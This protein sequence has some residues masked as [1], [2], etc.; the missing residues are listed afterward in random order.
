MYEYDPIP[1]LE[2][3][4]YTEREASFLYLVGRNSG[5]FLRRQFLQFAQ[6]HAGALAQNFVNK[7]LTDRYAK[8]LD[9]G[10]RRHI[11]HLHSGSIYAILRMQD[12]TLRRQ[13]S[14]HEMV[15]RLLILDY[16]L[17]QLGLRW[18]STE[19]EKAEYLE[20]ELKINPECFPRG[21]PRA[22]SED[23]PGIR[24]FP[25]H[26]PF[27]VLRETK[28][29]KPRIR[30]TYFD[31]GTATVKAFERY[32]AI[33]RELFL[34]LSD[35]DLAYVS[36]SSRNFFEAER[37]FERTLSKPKKAARL[38]PKGP[39]H[40]ARYFAAQESW[41]RTDPSFSVADLCSL[42][43]GKPIY[44]QPEHEILRAAWRKG[45]ATFEQALT[46][47][48]QRTAANAR[49]T[50]Q[51]MQRSYPIFGYK[52]HAEASP[53]VVNPLLQLRV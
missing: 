51:L 49:F 16:L 10:Q 30:F 24:Y 20:K 47:L 40:L 12:A 53:A 18:L 7:L 14:D 45:M 1:S 22:G 19:E 52:N 11:Y 37:V 35:F 9:Y 38:L 34:R 44:G 25:D 36:V 2:R 50:T 3:L 48:D 29:N 33:Y 15:T 6:G 26:F 27:A 4:G 43:D 42:E 28:Q 32:L 31:A 23:S 39:E 21:R 46:R 8:V 5:Y 13:K 41:E 17:G